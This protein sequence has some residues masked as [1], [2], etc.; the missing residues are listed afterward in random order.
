[1][2]RNTSTGNIFEFGFELGFV[3][4]GTTSS[5]CITCLLRHHFRGSFADIRCRS[6]T[7]GANSRKRLEGWRLRVNHATSCRL[8]RARSCTYWETD[9]DLA[10]SEG[11]KTSHLRDRTQSWRAHLLQCIYDPKI[12]LA[13]VPSCMWEVPS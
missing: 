6:L 5:T 12:I 1:M 2:S 8:Q 10:S 4:G 7:T 13:I 3:V 11:R 9:P